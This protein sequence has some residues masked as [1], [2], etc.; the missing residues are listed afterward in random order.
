MKIEKYLQETDP[1]VYRRLKKVGK[2]KK[3]IRLGDSVE[4]LMKH[5]SYKREG[6]RIRQVKWG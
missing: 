6:R 1:V 5:N 2:K 4:N 3:K